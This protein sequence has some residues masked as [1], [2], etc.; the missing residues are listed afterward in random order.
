MTL[1]RVALA[2]LLSS[3]PGTAL[4]QTEST[5]PAT[6]PASP[7]PPAEQVEEVTVHGVKG[8]PGREEMTSGEV[9]QLPG[10][11]GDAFRAIEAMPGV[12]PIV[13]GLPYF[14]VRGA[15]P[16]NTGFFIDGVRVPALFHLGVGAAVV[17][18]GLI[19][20]VDFYPGGYPARFGRYTGG[21]L[22]GEL[23]PPAERTH[24]EAS[25][26]LLD[27]GGLV[28]V[29]IADG[30]G[31]IEASGRY[32]YPGP[33]LSLFAPNVGLQYWDYQTRARWR[34]DD[35]NEIG[36]FIFGSYDD[37][38]SLDSSTGKW[39]ELLGIQFH[40]VDL[41]W[42][43]KTGD[44]G[45]LR[46]ALTLGYD[47]SEAGSSSS[48]TTTVNG[49]EG[50]TPQTVSTSSQ[51][52]IESET[53]GLRSEWMDALSPEIDAR[54]GSDV[55]VEPYQVVAP[56]TGPFNTNNA[57]SALG[58]SASNFTQVDVNGG[59]YGELDWRPTPR[60]D[61]RPGLRLDAFTSRSP[62]GTSLLGG[63]SGTG[64]AAGGVDPRLAGRWEMTPWLAWIAALG[65]AHQA[66][67]I[68]LPSPGLQFAQLARGLQST[69]QYSAGAEVQLPL[70]FTA[71]LDAFLQ[72]YT[73]IA[74]LYETCPP[75]ETSCT[76]D[77]R[78]VG[79]EL[80]VKRKLTERFTGWLSYTLSSSTRDSFF[81]NRWMTRLSEFDRPH[82][83]NL[84]L[85]AD[86]GKRWRAGARLMAYSGLPYS[87]STGIEGP[88]NAREP[89]F[90]R[91]DVRL[92]KKWQ[93]LGGTLTLVFEWLNALLS[94]ESFGTT[95]SGQVPQCTP[96]E[97]G[98]ITFPSIGVEEAW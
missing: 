38:T 23:T 87:T 30:R 94:Q 11:F 69:F 40:R 37:L 32:G 96:Q 98:P 78:A 2:L 92:E 62:T 33:L 59:L 90:M 15:P 1:R 49:P 17:H 65:V 24:A 67:N 44:T 58:S 6:S 76:F 55:V 50:P 81:L 18:P 36:A 73:G 93:A 53:V 3:W 91:L 56:G 60:V 25:V 72:D 63:D 46:V 22:S 31:E 68:P 21:I 51:Y 35:R 85:A 14:L 29:P 16:G 70:K 45:H 28:D 89:P 19:D 97:I 57:S 41:R 88:P 20:R 61:L 10:A 39:Q 48:S 7:T 9:K 27:A 77:G 5:K 75:G 80:I 52:A 43:H 74:D 4:A 71:T 54:V 86:L 79:M 13:S 12:T 42:D 34:L 95:C 26:R 84:V 66:S 47:R 83:V 82:V 64:R 8:E